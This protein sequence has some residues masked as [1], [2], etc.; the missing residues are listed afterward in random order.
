MQNFKFNNKSKIIFG[1]NDESVIAEEI[2][3]LGAK[4]VMIHYGMNSIVKSGLLGRIQS[5]LDNAKIKYIKFGGVKANPTKTHAIKGVEIA[6]KN[7][8]DFVLAV[9]G[10]SVID[11][12][13]AICAGA[14]NKDIWTYYINAEKA[15]TLTAA[16]PL[17]VVLTIPAAGSEC[18]TASVLQDDDNLGA[19]YCLSQPP[20]RSK[21]AFINPELCTTLPKE[22]VAYGASDILAHLLERYFSTD[23]NVV[24]TD[25][26]LT[27]AMQA[28][29]EIAPKVY[30]DPTDYQNMAELCLLGTLAHNGMLNM[31]RISQ[32]WGTHQID[33]TLLSGIKNIA[34]GAGLAVVFPAWLKHVAKTKP[35][36]ILQFAREVMGCSSIADGIA[37][38]EKFYKSLGLAT[39]L[40]GVGF[41]V[42]EIKGLVKTAF[43]AD[44]VLGGYGQL[45]QSDIESV[46]VLAR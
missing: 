2:K 23:E 40:K 31:G 44:I 13:K 16:L 6:R 8:V 26:L 11:S 36:K 12:A 10:G 33:N 22:Q 28:M 1:K 25:K 42:N 35:T 45:S 41:D 15:K 39:T 38:L 43:P 5:A 27:G 14:V 19:K 3:S 4:K 17:G 46:V 24:V 34:H 18:S 7:K 21:F 30:A 37:G 20:L 29:F 32:D 9:G